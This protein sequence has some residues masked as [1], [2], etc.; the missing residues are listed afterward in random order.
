MFWHDDDLWAQEQKLT[1]SDP[2]LQLGGEGFGRAVALD[3]DTLLVGARREDSVDDGSGS[4]Y[5]FRRQS[6]EWK[7]VARIVA[8]DGGFDDAFGTS[9]ALD[10]GRGVV[11]AESDVLEPGP[12]VGS[13]YYYEGLAATPPW[14]GL[15]SPLAGTTCFPCLTGGGT[16]VGGTPVTL[17][18]DN[19]LPSVPTALVV[20]LSLLSVPS[21]GARSFPRPICSCPAW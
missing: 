7:L 16:L 17:A 9:V 11:G 8:S 10:G 6:S 1:I 20:G 12:G 14:S 18:L 19:V 21:R 3:G 5:L 15:G 4:V 2:V 13:A